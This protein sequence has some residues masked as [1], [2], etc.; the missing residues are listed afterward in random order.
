MFYFF[1]GVGFVF[2]FLFFSP[3]EFHQV[4]IVLE[5]WYWSK[6]QQFGTKGDSR[7]KSSDPNK[8]L[9]GY[10]YD[11]K[12]FSF[13]ANQFLNFEEEILEYPLLG[14]GFFRYKKI[15][16][17]ITYYSSYGEILWKKNSHSYP[18][19]SFLGN[20]NFLISGDGN[21]VLLVDING[22]PTGA[23]QLDGRFLTDMAHTVL[24]GSVILFSGGEIFRLDPS[25]NIIWKLTNLQT[26]QKVLLFYKSIAI[27][28]D[29]N[30]VAVHFLKDTKDYI[31]VLG[32][33]GETLTI[34][35]LPNKY[36]HKLY[37]AVSEKGNVLVNANDVLLMF[38]VKGEILHQTIKKKTEKVYH[39]AFCQENIFVA[40]IENTLIFLNSQ[41][42]LIRKYPISSL[43][44]RLFSSTQR[45]QFF[46]ET[47]E[48]IIAF[49]LFYD[50]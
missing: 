45:G 16:E 7:F 41:G 33:K 19:A 42:Y 47:E 5:N 20:L 23:R 38:S 31:A 15:G 11:G 21:Q 34:F 43:N 49:Q 12:F 17:Y 29:G 40:D 27:S 24:H 1:L 8:V 36:P 9:N 46:L 25:G 35:H 18:F 32:S 26:E 48:E 50:K 4:P 28:P 37:M 13:E 22:N 6:Q 30:F 14:K 39:V 3:N 2:L 10:K 44:R